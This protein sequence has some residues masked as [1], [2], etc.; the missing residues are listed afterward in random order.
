MAAVALRHPIRVR[1]LEAMHLHREIS[2]TM[3]VN[4]QM[5]KD[6]EAL[7]GRPHQQQVSSVDYHLHALEKMNCIYRT[8]REKR[9]GGWENFYRS[10]AVAYFS[11]EEWAELSLGQRRAISRVVAQGFIVQ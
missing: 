8:R 1:A 5:G 3:F 7:Q 2:A 10:S 6:L 9:R 11:D 4:E